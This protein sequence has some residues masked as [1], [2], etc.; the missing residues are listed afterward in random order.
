M[1]ESAAIPI[2][3]RTII[4]AMFEYDIVLS[5]AGEQRAQVERVAECLRLAGVKVFYDAYEKSDL[6]GKDLYQHLSEVYQKK[7]R[8]CIVFASKDY[9]NKAWT[10]HELRSA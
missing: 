6:W 4:G 9:A 7:A 10:N 2:G 1:K 3:V 5:F 8:Y